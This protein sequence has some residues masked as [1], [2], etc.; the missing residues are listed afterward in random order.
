MYVSNARLHS[1][2]R[3]AA[4]SLGGLGELLG[5]GGQPVLLGEFR[6][7]REEPREE[8]GHQEDV[9]G[10][11]RVLEKVALGMEGGTRRERKEKKRSKTLILNY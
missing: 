8:E 4:H 10:A 5:R 9:P 2:A 7:A 3:S 6:A 1:R 11:G